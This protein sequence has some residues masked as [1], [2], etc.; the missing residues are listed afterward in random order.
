M[1][2]KILFA[3]LLLSIVS[4]A[5]ASYFGGA[6]RLAI[7]NLFSATR[8]DDSPTSANSSAIATDPYRYG[9]MY[10]YIDST[11]VSTQ[12]I[13]ILPQFSNDN[14]TTWYSYKGT[15]LGNIEYEDVDTASGLYES[16]PITYVGCD[17]RVRLEGTN[18][19]AANYFDV[20]ID[21]EFW[22]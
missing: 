21:V 6:A 8:I 16:F 19:T 13:K 7:T 2:K 10:V 12:T 5:Q 15:P 3:I 4:F 1:F 20:T 22:D 11:G 9:M 18:T 17:F 14:G